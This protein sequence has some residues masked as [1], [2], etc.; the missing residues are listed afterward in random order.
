MES[1]SRNLKLLGYG[2]VVGLTY[3][4]GLRLLLH[5]FPNNRFFSV[6]SVSF[7]LLLPFCMGF[8]AVFLVERERR[9]SPWFWLAIAVLPVAGGLLGSLLALWEGLI[10]VVMFAPI[11]LI[12]AILGGL[13]GGLVARYT[14]KVSVTCVAILPLLVNPWEQN[15]FS[16]YEIRAV[17]TQVDIHAPAST[18]WRS[19]ES[20][21]TIAPESSLRLGA[22]ASDS[23]VHLMR[24]FLMKAWV[25]LDTRV[26]KVEYCSSKQWISGNRS[27]N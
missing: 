21:S 13:T 6:M 24:R 10:C 19:I 14:R 25:A 20:V 7:L 4:L 11:G 3:G 16:R 27:E 9:Q 23:R 1:Q 22:V 5:W 2:V 12:C 17:Q 15:L 18:V 26:S 8:I